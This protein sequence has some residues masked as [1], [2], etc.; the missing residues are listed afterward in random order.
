[1]ISGIRNSA[2]PL[3]KPCSHR[4][5]AT[6]VSWNRCSTPGVLRDG[7]HYGW[8]HHG[9]SAPD[10]SAADGSGR[11]TGIL[12]CYPSSIHPAPGEVDDAEMYRTFNMGVGMI[13]VVAPEDAATVVA[14]LGA[15]GEICHRIGEIVEG[16]GTVRYV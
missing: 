14:D 12:A 2:E 1:M 11:G 7:S 6:I 16:D 4:T 10:T 8:R 13:L 5:A 15:R 3:R 9:Q